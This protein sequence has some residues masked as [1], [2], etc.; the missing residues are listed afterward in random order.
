[1]VCS[2]CEG[3]VVRLAVPEELREH[4]RGWEAAGVC[5]RCLALQPAE[6]ADDDPDWSAF[7]EAFPDGEAAVPM[8]L[9]VGLLDQLALNRS[10]LSALVERA[11]RAGADPRLVLDRLATSGSIQANYDIDRRR[12]QLEQLS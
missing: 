5:S 12:R 6:A 11:E 8:A 7:G 1:M 4:V 3:E 9:V 2:E 10:A